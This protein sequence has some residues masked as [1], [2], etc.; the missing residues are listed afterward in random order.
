MFHSLSARLTVTVLLLAFPLGAQQAPATAPG[1][2][3][4]SPQIVAP[5]AP[6]FYGGYNIGVGD[7]LDIRVADE[8]MLTGRYQVDQEGHVQMPLLTGPI[9]AAGLTTFDLAKQLQIELKKQDIMREPSVIV[10]IA[11]GMTQNVTVL[12]AVVRPGIYQIE[13]PTTVLDL[14]SRAGG[15]QPNAGNQLI[16]TPRGQGDG[17][18]AASQ[19]SKTI[20]LPG[21]MSGADLSANVVAKAGDVITVTT[22]PVVFVVGAVV[23][24]GAFTVQNTRSEMTVLQAVAMAEGTQ[25][26]ASLGKAVIVRQSADD[27]QRE[28]IPIDLGDVMKGKEVDRVLVANDIL[29]V[30]QSGFKLGMRRVADVAVQAAGQAV[31]YGVGIRVIP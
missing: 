28:E 23:R 27:A 26:T 5:P 18:A 17:S 13:Q 10:F 4:T 1:S 15:L 20:D 29:F 22:A 7:I 21:L 24:P 8:D 14:L 30:P 16:I 12:G 25:P 9:K 31:G 2:G 19:T 6:D 3:A 11:R